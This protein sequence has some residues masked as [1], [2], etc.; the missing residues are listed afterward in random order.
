MVTPVHGDPMGG[1]RTA[2]CM[3]QRS[4]AYVP[5]SGT[6]E[7]A[8]GQKPVEPK[9]DAEY[10]KDVNASVKAATPAQLKNHGTN[11]SGC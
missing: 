10:A 8:M 11:A 5:A 7:A 6:D 3:C 9:I 1:R 4:R 2:G